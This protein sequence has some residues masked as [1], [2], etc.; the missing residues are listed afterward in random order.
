MDR[1]YGDILSRH[2]RWDFTYHTPVELHED[3]P[4]AVP[5]PLLDA[6]LAA[7]LPREPVDDGRWVIECY[8]GALVVD[9]PSGRRDWPAGCEHEHLDTEAVQAPPPPP[10]AAPAVPATSTA[11][12]APQPHQKPKSRPKPAG[13][14]VEVGA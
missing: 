6:V 8:C 12:Q 1:L 5:V 7:L 2:G 14:V 11:Q 10:P 9:T 13:W 3:Y 4:A